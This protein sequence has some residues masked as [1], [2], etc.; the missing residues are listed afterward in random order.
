MVSHHVILK[1]VFQGTLNLTHTISK[2]FPILWKSAEKIKGDTNMSPLIS[3]PP[4]MQFYSIIRPLKL[5]LEVYIYIYFW[6][7]VILWRRQ[8]LTE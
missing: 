8:V 1:E 2:S 3:S 5:L 4:N 6:I 7:R